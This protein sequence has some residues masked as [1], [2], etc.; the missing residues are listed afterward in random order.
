MALQFVT[1]QPSAVVQPGAASITTVG[2]ANAA[3]AFGDNSD[4]TYV[5]LAARIR[6][7]LDRLIVS[8]PVPTTIPAGAMIYSVKLRRRQQTLSSGA[9]PLTSHHWYSALDS[10]NPVQVAG[11]QYPVV[12]TFITTQG[13]T[14]ASGTGG[15]W[16]EE[17]VRED[18]AGPAS[19]PWN[20][21]TNLNPPTY[22]LGRGDDSVTSVLRVSTVWLDITYQQQ[23]IVTVTG[24]TT[25]STDTRPTITW[26]WFSPD[27]QPQQ[28][29]RVAIYTAAQVAMPGFTPFVSPCVE[30]SGWTLGEDLKWTATADLTDGQYYAYVQGQ[31]QFA[32][33]GDFLTDIAS[34][35][36]TRAASPL[37]P[38]PA[39]SLLSA[40]Y[41]YT[42]GRVVLTAQAGGLLPATT[43]LMFITS[44]DGGVSWQPIHGTAVYLPVSGLATVTDYHYTAPSNADSRYAAIAYNG[45][46]LTAS[47]APSNTITVTP[48]DQRFWWIHP[49]D[50]NLNCVL[51]VAPA[52]GEQGIKI[53]LP[54]TQGYFEP[55]GDPDTI[56]YAVI[57]DGPSHGR[58]YSIE[59]LY[60]FGN[61]GYSI[62][63][64]LTYLYP[65]MDQL[66][67]SGGVPLLFK[68]PDATLA[69]TRPAPATDQD[70]EETRTPVPGKPSSNASILR[71]LTLAEVAAPSSY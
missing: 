34:I 63:D 14:D 33:V 46:P 1:A 55:I 44:Q 68:L 15:N 26:S 62:S 7:R 57:V 21:G 37:S 27:N 17:T 19:R 51:P 49:N 61:S 41:D 3:I 20:V 60:G 30:Q 23:S 66:D 58:R 36:W 54:R 42:T 40:A 8:F 10:S 50:P 64:E 28:A 25:P 13:F 47:T 5:Q 59:L 52:K 70:T 43:A 11:G 31:A 69:W 56:V 29:Y 22:E 4:S 12:E 38:P 16:V 71:K 35:S 48:Q 32:G 18:L 39:A 67:K 24:P 53:K 65:L 45:T 6:N 9:D 2:A